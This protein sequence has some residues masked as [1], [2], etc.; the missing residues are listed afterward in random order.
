MP[1]HQGTPRFPL[2]EVLGEAGRLTREGTLGSVWSY[3]GCSRHRGGGAGDAPP[4][5]PENDRCR[6]EP[7]I[8]S[9]LQLSPVVPNVWLLIQTNQPWP[10][11]DGAWC[12]VTTPRALA[13]VGTRVCTMAWPKSQ[14]P[15]VREHDCGPQIGCCFIS[16]ALSPV[17]LSIPASTWTS[18]R[19]NCGSKHSPLH[20]GPQSRPH[21]P[22]RH[23][24]SGHQRA[25]V[26]TGVR[27]CRLCPQP[28]RESHLPGV[29]PS[30]P[31]GPLGP[32]RPALYPSPS[33]PRP[34]IPLTHQAGPAPGLLLST[35]LST[36]TTR[37]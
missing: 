31:R 8:W 17:C 5:R 7:L 25:P 3:W 14:E 2:R 19:H 6:G 26:S 35:L 4:P 24:L 9:V 33:P 23:P 13:A 16:T 30:P 37:S 21:P 22:V 11:S 29:N 12:L 15:R 10:K 27:S 36:L 20:P 34:G 1:T 18:P 28:S 32:A